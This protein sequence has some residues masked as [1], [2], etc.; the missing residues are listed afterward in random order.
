[1][2]RQMEASEVR[3]RLRGVVEQAKRH[4]AERRA[5]N[6]DASRAYDTFLAEVAIPAFHAVAQALT[7]E[8]YRF[9]VFTPGQ[10]VRLTPEFSQDEFI[11]L[12]LDTT[13][14]APLVMLTTARGR[15]RHQIVIEQ[16]LFEGRVLP[17]ISQDDVVV[18]VIDALLPFVER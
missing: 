17:D 12:A 18:V 15:G 13:G 8:G 14:D 7:G 4:A 5:R 2:L 9:K 1:M 11:E 10:S 6:D 3:R 16:P